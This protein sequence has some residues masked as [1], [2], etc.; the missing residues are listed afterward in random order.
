MSVIFR[1]TKPSEII[2]VGDVLMLSPE[3]QYVTLWRN[4]WRNMWRNILSSQILNI[5][6]KTNDFS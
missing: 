6:N 1:K 3:N 5:V 2:E 4:M